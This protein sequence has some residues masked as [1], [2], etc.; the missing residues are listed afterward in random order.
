[1]EKV[2]VPLFVLVGE[3]DPRCPVRQIDNYLDR[4]RALGKTHEVLRFDAGHGSR[5]M[6]ERIR[7]T[8]KMIDFV[9]RHHGTQP[10][11]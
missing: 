4:L 1:V 9:A 3:N 11:Q 8:E 7:Q 2:D 10:P 5:K 6:G